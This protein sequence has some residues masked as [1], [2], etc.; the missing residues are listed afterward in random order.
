M[1]KNTII[2]LI[3][4][5]LVLSI[6]AFKIIK[7]KKNS[8]FDPAR[9][10]SL[11][12][13]EAAFQYRHAQIIAEGK[14]DPFQALKNDKSVQ[15]PETINV[16]KYYTVMMEFLYGY[17]YRIFNFGLPFHL[18]LIYLNCLFSS[19]SLIPVFF[20]TRK[21]FRNDAMAIGS[22]LFYITTPAS[23]L[24]TAT[25]SFL[26]EDFALLFIL[27]SIW[28]LLAMFYNKKHALF[29]IFAGLLIAFSL[30]SW[31]FSNFVYMCMLPFF[32]WICITKPELL[33]NFFYCLIVIFIAGIFVP[34][35]R[36]RVFITSIFMC[37]AYAMFTCYFLFKVYKKLWQRA[38]FVVGIFMLIMLFRNILGLYEP[39]YTHV[40]GVFFDK[41]K[42]L[43]QKP[44]NPLLLSFNT[45][46]LWESAFNS[47]SIEELWQF[48]K[49]TFPLGLAGACWLLWQ[50]NEFF[51]PARLIAVMTIILFALSLMVKRILIVAAP[52]AAVTLWG[53]LINIKK[54]DYLK[55]GSAFL[56]CLN[57]IG[58]NTRP[59]DPPRFIPSSYNEIFEWINSNT[60]ITDAFVAH[61]P[62]SPIVLLNTG[63]PEVLHPKFENLAIREKYEQF[64]TAMYKLDE[65][66]I[67]E[68]CR[69][70]KA[71]YLIYDWGFFINDNKDSQRYLANAVPEI[72]ENTVAA[73]LHFRSPSLKHFKFQYRNTAFIV[74]EVVDNAKDLPLEKLPYSPIYDSGI[75][76]KEEGFYKNTRKTYDDIIIPYALKVNQSNDLLA[77]KRPDLVVGLLKPLVIQIPRGS[78]AISILAQAYIQLQQ[79]EQ[80][81]DLLEQ[82]LD[83][84]NNE[85]ITLESYGVNMLELLADVYFYKKLY[86]KSSE[87][88]N[89]CLEIPGHGPDVNK[90]LDI[91]S[92]IKSE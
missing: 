29:S 74:Y 39:A 48:G 26:R 60:E 61:I 53:C 32:Y 51:H 34:V 70:N 55:L 43:L 75:Y 62:L 9:A 64:I 1:K 81:Q 24:R 23:F 54:Q 25:G 87:V 57:F 41:I 50:K 8:H 17:L 90:K 86:D 68:F 52:F 30:S 20:I 76:T 21:I 38:A 44:D 37:S 72:S 10:G 13:S 33:K 58:M 6:T 22:C 2:F 83:K 14:E 49:I 85:D 67:Y 80:A 89:K 82:Y 18:F 40:Y 91:L 65:K 15:Y 5:A 56:L 88:L 11:F 7:V 31:H 28:L 77:N 46:Q 73:H 69:R 12:Y 79:Y 66:D 47:A 92:K 59:I 84:M 4:A 16:F 78:E 71:K 27:T 3:L 35:L 45:K 36:A 63:R 19:L 42:F